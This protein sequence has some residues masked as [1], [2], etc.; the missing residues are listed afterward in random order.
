MILYE[1]A[2]S[3][4]EKFNKSEKKFLGF[5]FNRLKDRTE[6]VNFAEIQKENGAYTSTFIGIRDINIDKIRGSVQKYMDFNKNFAPK[7]EVLEERW[8][9][10][11]T[12][13][14]SGAPL[15]P[16]ILYKIKDD[17]FVYDGN[18]RVSVAKFLNFKVIEAEV[19]EFLVS[20]DTKENVIYREKFN[21]DKNTGIDNI[22]FTETNQYERLIKEIEEYNEFLKEKENLNLNFIEISSRWY[23]DVYVTITEIIKNND[24]I[25]NFEGQTISDIFVHF[26]DHKYFKSEKKKH[27]VGFTYSVIDFVNFIKTYNNNEI[28]NIFN[29]NNKNKDL[30]KILTNI[31][32]R[33]SL[34][35]DILFKTDTLKRITGLK[36]EHDFV[37]LNKIDDYIKEHKID[38]F[39][40]GIEYWYKNVFQ[41]NVEIFKSKI[42]YLPDEFKKLANKLLKKEE[43]LFYSLGNYYNIYKEQVE[44]SIKIADMITNYII[45]IYIPIMYSLMNDRFDEKDLEKFYYGIQNR[46]SYLV[47]YKQEA[48]M[49]EAE[50]LY[51][52]PEDKFYSR[53]GSWFFMKLG[54]S[55]KTNKA[56]EN[57]I[58]EFEK[59]LDDK[60]LLRILLDRYGSIGKYTTI[61]NFTKVKKFYKD[62]K[63]D[64]CWIENRLI[65]DIEKIKNQ[66][67]IMVYYKTKKVIEILNND[68]AI[69][70]ILDFYAEI[71]EYSIFLERDIF[72]IDIIDLAFE[73]KNR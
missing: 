35:K 42:N 50:E 14:V 25:D 73:Y 22:F 1:Q 43:N 34:D 44:G 62:V 20:K 72:F 64:S 70:S 7:N 53:T 29:L 69:F 27:D 52:D 4:Y 37:M 24:I 32:K 16:I 12:A 31:D 6:L 36:L 19:I 58:I 71:L 33:K 48:T 5:S 28:D 66:E 3:A 2:K 9:S 56:I 67:E 68:D 38:N 11:Y 18:H 41:K 21:F 26:L 65:E 47:E 51:F 59:D 61:I 8:C 49:K 23:E 63:K 10:I 55:F 15:P 54:Y 13:F 30:L 57:M 39:E 17:Y 46:Y 40:N 45:E 60:T